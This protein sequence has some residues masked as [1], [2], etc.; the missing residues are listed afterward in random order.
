MQTQ[1]GTCFFFCKC[2]RILWPMYQY[3]LIPYWMPSRTI[4]KAFCKRDPSTFHQSCTRLLCRNNFHILPTLFEFW[5]L[6]KVRVRRSTRFLAAAELKC[7]RLPIFN[8]FSASPQ[9]NN[10]QHEIDM[11]RLAKKLN[12]AST[13]LR[14]TN[15]EKWSPV[16]DRGVSSAL[17]GRGR[18]VRGRGGVNILLYFVFCQYFVFFNILYFSIFCILS[19]FCNLKIDL[20]LKHSRFAKF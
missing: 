20:I 9:F 14:K 8:A 3:P 1:L 17:W 16:Q 2:R 19:I 10:H 15:L 13:S 12:T 11:V 6:I 5:I 4:L 7:P 18:G